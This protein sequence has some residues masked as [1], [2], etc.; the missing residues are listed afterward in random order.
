MSNVSVSSLESVY[1]QLTS[2]ANLSNFWN[3]FDTVFGSS[4][5]FATVAIFKLTNLTLR[6]VYYGK[7]F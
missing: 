7:Y 4:H 2:F 3:L 6:T 5:D 1:A